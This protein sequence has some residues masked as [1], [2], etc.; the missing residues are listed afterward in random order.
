MN[1]SLLALGAGALLVL[2]LV[3]L[4]ILQP[5]V[6]HVDPRIRY[7][8]F[9]LLLGI[10]V[11]TQAIGAVAAAVSERAGAEIGCL[12]TGLLLGAACMLETRKLRRE[13]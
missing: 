13:F 2:S 8:L 7:R 9:A 3:L 6:R 1:V 5:R 12:I 10:G 4:I 11:G